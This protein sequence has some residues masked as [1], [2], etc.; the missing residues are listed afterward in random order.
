MFIPSSPIDE[1]QEKNKK[2]I[3]SNYT[4]ISTY[5]MGNIGIKKII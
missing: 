2:E 4:Y 1:L 5:N 3:S